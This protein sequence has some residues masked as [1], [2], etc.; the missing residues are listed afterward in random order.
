MGILTG[1]TD[2]FGLDIGTT[3]IRVVELHGGGKVRALARYGQ[4]AVDSKIS[5]SDANADMQK[6]VQYVRQVI[7]DARITTRN[8]A[9]GVPSQKVFTAVIDID[10]LTPAEL[11]K[12]IQYQADSL[13]PTP[14]A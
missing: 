9:V 6:M 12:T 7:A 3:A 4:I 11:S 13:I 1:V 8:V 10:R 14:L 5:Q 2:F